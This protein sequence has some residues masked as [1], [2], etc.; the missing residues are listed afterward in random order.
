MELLQ[1]DKNDRV[2]ILLVSYLQQHVQ[3]IDHNRVLR[4]EFAG[5]SIK[6]YKYIAEIEQADVH[7]LAQNH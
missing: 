6:K 4:L 1:F 7:Q 5:A 2:G 3:D